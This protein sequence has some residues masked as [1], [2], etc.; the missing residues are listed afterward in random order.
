MS[1]IIHCQEPWKTLIAQGTKTIEGKVGK[2]E[3]FT[4]YLNQ[5]IEVGESK[6]ILEKIVHY[7]NL[8]A[9]LLE[10]WIRAAPHAT[11]FEDAKNKYLAVMNPK[12][13]TQVFNAERIQ[14]DG[15]ICAL[16]ISLVN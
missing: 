11:S 2:E 8:N 13:N 15:G 10:C 16:H 7:P 12:N 14:R 1:L 5:I 3:Q 9:Y 6:V 4:P